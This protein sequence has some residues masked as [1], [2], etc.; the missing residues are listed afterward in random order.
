[1]NSP[2]LTV[3][4]GIC[5]NT[6]VG[7]YFFPGTVTGETYLHMLDTYAFPTLNEMGLL[8]GDM[9]WQQDGA[10]PHYARIVRDR[11]NA[12][13]PDRW[14]GRRGPLEWPPRSPDL[15]PMDFSV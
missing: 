5:P 6:V 3:W 7:P 2:G 8:D 4:A 9:W 1:M 12:V 10:P 13:F 11:L 15:S 14:M